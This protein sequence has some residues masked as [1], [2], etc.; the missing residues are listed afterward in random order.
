MFTTLP[1]STKPRPCPASIII[2]IYINETTIDVL[3]KCTKFPRA[4]SRARGG[5]GELKAMDTIGVQ[6]VSL[7]AAP[8]LSTP[9]SILNSTSRE[10]GDRI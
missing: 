10:I 1:V 8:A 5:D 6:N 9:V 4:T 2:L 7:K 3:L